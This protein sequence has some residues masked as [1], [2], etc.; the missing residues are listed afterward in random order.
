MKRFISI[1][2]N[3]NFDIH[4]LMVFVAILISLEKVLDILGILSS[5]DNSLVQSS[6]HGIYNRR[7]LA[8]FCNS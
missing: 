4:K 2:H 1:R 3:K 5:R 6:W 8:P 7:G